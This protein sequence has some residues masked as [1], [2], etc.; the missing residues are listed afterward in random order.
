MMRTLLVSFLIAALL[1]P[2]LGKL[3]V[4]GHYQANLRYY[5]EVLCRNQDKPELNCDGH[6]ILAERLAATQ[7]SPPAAPHGQV[8]QFELS[9]FD[10]GKP[11][12]PLTIHTKCSQWLFGEPQADALPQPALAAI[13]PPPETV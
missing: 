5:K 3:A 2:V 13:C 12:T 9:A 6:C 10:L 1:M 11:I 4:W 8:M 7:P